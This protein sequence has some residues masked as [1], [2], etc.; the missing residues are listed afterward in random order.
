MKIAICIPV[1][2]DGIIKAK[3]SLA[4]MNVIKKAKD[5]EVIPMFQFGAY[6]FENRQEMV[7]FAQLQKCSHIFFVDYDMIFDPEILNILLSRNK[8]IIGVNYMMRKLP[9]RTTVLADEKEKITLDRLFK[10]HGIGMGVALIKMS[11]FDKISPPWFHFDFDERGRI[12]VSED[13]Y[14]CNK[15]RQEG[16]DIWVDPTIKV[17]HLGDYI[18]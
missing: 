6:V 16:Y 17:G 11:V 8:D 14:F 7:F 9:P 3:T 4:I 15:A 2:S 13:Y 10:C 5:Y 12:S 1:A 18:Y